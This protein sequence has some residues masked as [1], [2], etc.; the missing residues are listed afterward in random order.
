[1]GELILG[2]NTKYERYEELLLKRDQLY[3][4]AC[5]IETSYVKEFGDLLL[6]DFELKI[7][8]IKKKKMI[9]YC[10][11]A[12][13]HG[14]AIDVTDMNEQIKRSMEIYNMQ[15]KEMMK[16]KKDAEESK[17]SPAYKVERAKRAYRRLAKCIHPDI[18]PAA[19]ANEEIRSLWGRIVAAY[20]ANDD[21]ELDNLEVLV[22]KV[23]KDN[24]ELVSTP[25]IDDIDE[26]MEKLEEEINSIIT[27]VPYV[28]IDLLSDEAKVQA[29]K[30]EIMKE[31][32]EYTRYSEELSEMLRR[33][34]LEG[35]SPIA[36]VE[37]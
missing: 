19:F 20:H 11:T 12:I 14:E 36:W 16:S 1:M 8:C 21:E 23:L 15:L 22:R 6:R 27:T 18:N 30:D 7:G 17:V 34:M 33:L 28:Y 9:A 4:E 25:V 10:Q 37:D 24:G 2:D 32:E 31:I 35:G 29:K 13:N 5:S 3:R 26:R